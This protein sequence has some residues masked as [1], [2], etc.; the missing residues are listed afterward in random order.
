MKSQKLLFSILIASIVITSIHYT[1]NA[2]FIDK[3]PEPQWITT[4]G[5]YLTWS[6]M[7]IL[8]IIGYWLYSQG[9]R[10]LSYCCLG[11][12]S[13][14]GLS[15]PMH[16][17]YGGMSEFSLKMHTFIWLDFVAGALVIGCVISELLLN[18]DRFEKKS[19]DT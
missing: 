13:L 8:G 16:Y 4:F 9:K 3:Y 2:I 7:S 10:W 12:Y 11:I 6:A 14:T 18:R 5:I 17:F 19:T 1:D 15:S